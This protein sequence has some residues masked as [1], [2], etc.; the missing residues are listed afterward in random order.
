MA[1][2][3][4]ATVVRADHD[5]IG[6]RFLYAANRPAT[7]FCDN[8]SN[9]QRLFGEPNASQYV[10]DGIGEAVRTHRPQLAARFP[11]LGEPGTSIPD[12]DRDR[13]AER[14]TT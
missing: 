2:L 5:A 1:D 7:P 12:P 9:V 8:E 11:A 6:R 4:D 14:E 13:R 3:P 10:K